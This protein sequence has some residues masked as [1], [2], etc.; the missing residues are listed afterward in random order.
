MLIGQLRR[1]ILELLNFCERQVGELG[2]LF[3]GEIR[4][5]QAASY[6]VSSWRPSW[7]PSCLA[8]W[9]A[10][11]C[12][13]GTSVQRAQDL[14]FVVSPNGIDR[15]IF[16]SSL[17]VTN[18]KQ[19]WFKL[20]SNCWSWS[21]KLRPKAGARSDGVITKRNKSNPNDTPVS[22]AISRESR[23]R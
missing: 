12:S 20:S 3:W 1:F 10:L 6:L 14:T 13:K 2:N 17:S 9:Y 16:D 21:S 22:I 7:R 4:L 23:T 11:I 19:Y 18:F 8:S 5:K 15:G